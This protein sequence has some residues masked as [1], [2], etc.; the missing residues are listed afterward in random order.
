MGGGMRQNNLSGR[1][2]HSFVEQLLN[3]GTL[4]L[5]CN[6]GSDTYYFYCPS[7]SA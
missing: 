7:G 3:K 1:S 6:K 5:H 2:L 4:V